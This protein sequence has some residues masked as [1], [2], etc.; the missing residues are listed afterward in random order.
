MA[1][2]S[3]GEDAPSETGEFQSSISSPA[4]HFLTSSEL[5]FKYSWDA[6]L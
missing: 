2:E 5:I 6:N 4:K 1:V 3:M